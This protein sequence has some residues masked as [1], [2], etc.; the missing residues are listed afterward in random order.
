MTQYHH[1]LDRFVDTQKQNIVLSNQMDEGS[2]LD[3][4]SITFFSPHNVTH[5]AKACT[6]V[7]AVTSGQ[8]KELDEVWSKN[9]GKWGAILGTDKQTSRP[10]ES[11]EILNLYV[12]IAPQDQT[13]T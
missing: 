4:G 8:R 1:M 6:P 2:S 7:S 11:S 10:F 9:D 5:S 13:Y 3:D 12:F